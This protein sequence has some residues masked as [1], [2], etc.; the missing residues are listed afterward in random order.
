MSRQPLKYLLATTVVATLAVGV[1]GTAAAAPVTGLVR[2]ADV[3]AT[4]SHPVIEKAY[5]VYRHHR[6]YWVEP[7]RR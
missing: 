5:W 3:Q 4:V 1:V 6:R 2:A 7:H